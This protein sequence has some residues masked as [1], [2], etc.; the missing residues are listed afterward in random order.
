MYPFHSG[1]TSTAQA[2]GVQ[3]PKRDDS[4]WWVYFPDPSQ[5]AGA[6]PVDKAATF[7]AQAQP[8]WPQGA[9]MPSGPSFSGGFQASVPYPMPMPPGGGFQASP[10]FSYT[11][12]S[13]PPQTAVVPYGGTP[14]MG[15]SQP[16]YPGYVQPGEVGDNPFKAAVEVRKA[17]TANWAVRVM[18]A[19]GGLTL[20]V[21]LIYAGYYFYEWWNGRLGGSTNTPAVTAPYQPGVDVSVSYPGLPPAYAVSGGWGFY[22]ADEQ[23]RVYIAFDATGVDVTR[24]N[25]EAATKGY[26]TV[27]VLE[28]AAGAG[29]GNLI[30]VDKSVLRSLLMKAKTEAGGFRAD[31]DSKYQYRF[32]GAEET[33]VRGRADRLNEAIDGALGAIE[34]GAPR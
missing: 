4:G 6:T 1:S 14:Y 29:G 17:A 9:Q 23:K 2:P 13:Y 8:S 20:T 21:L 22:V 18:A 25:S 19:G 15:H 32:V 12:P 7:Q 27:I 31:L 24:A 5:G 34:G 16:A 33:E 30:V 10:T 26:S 11:Q 28:G 3:A